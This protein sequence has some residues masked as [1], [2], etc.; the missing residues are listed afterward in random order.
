MEH[1]SPQEVTSV[2]FD[3]QLDA[4]TS[5][6]LINDV[7][8]CDLTRSGSSE[9]FAELFSRYRYPT[10]RLA[11]Y[12]SSAVDPDDV[13]AE[14]F[15]QVLD[16][17]QRG[18]GPDSAV[19]AYLFTAIRREVWKRARALKRVVPTDNLE[20]IDEPVL[21]EATGIDAS[22]RDR[23]RAAFQSL[24][25]RWRNVLWYLEVEGRKPREL[26]AAL[27][28]KPNGVSALLYRARVGLRKAYESQNPGRPPIDPLTGFKPESRSPSVDTKKPE[29][30]EQK[31][32][33]PRA[34][35]HVGRLEDAYLSI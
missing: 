20:L 16:Q 14:V 18:H 26:A 3:P 17:L 15:A 24:P 13:V 11:R 4:E 22:E 6:A 29:S 7:E 9:A 32:T 5:F 10:T 28:M 21:P 19:R 8:L 23:V 25:K 33:K 30:P 1:N 35:P 34:R 31:V 12:Y 27:G 2:E